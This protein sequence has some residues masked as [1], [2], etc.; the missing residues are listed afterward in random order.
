MDAPMKFNATAIRQHQASRL[1]TREFLET[2]K[3]ILGDGLKLCQRAKAH[4]SHNPDT[5]IIAVEKKLFYRLCYS[6]SLNLSDIH[7][8]IPFGVIYPYLLL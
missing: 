7:T 6:F 3:N 4:N 1:L 2:G 5:A 8:Q